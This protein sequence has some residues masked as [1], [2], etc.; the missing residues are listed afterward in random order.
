MRS[1]QS[2]HPRSTRAT[3]RHA[4]DSTIADESCIIVRALP[5]SYSEVPHGRRRTDTNGSTIR[6]R[7]SASSEIWAQKTGQAQRKGRDRKTGGS[8]RPS[9][10]GS[11]QTGS[12]IDESTLTISGQS[13]MQ[14]RSKTRLQEAAG[15]EQSL[16]T[17]YEDY[18]Q[19]PVPLGPQEDE[20][21]TISDP[22]V[23]RV[24][25]SLSQ[26]VWGQAILD[27]DHLG[28]WTTDEDQ[29]KFQVRQSAENLSQTWQS[30]FDSA[31]WQAFANNPSFSGWLQFIP[32]LD[33]QETGTY[34][35]QLS[36]SAG[37]TVDGAVYREIETE[38]YCVGVT[39][40]TCICAHC[41]L[42]CFGSEYA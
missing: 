22:E 14:T 3:Q 36:C 24:A 15:D 30:K 8:S 18:E 42:G 35:V 5:S 41:P 23:N 16:E 4:S 13:G 17:V 37:P 11:Q 38:N 26:A 27:L 34:S 20:S 25:E 21:P 19:Y 1:K 12:H 10:H 33:F 2:R 9:K 31:R 29:L 32:H 6:S 28:R 7:V 40:T 39:A